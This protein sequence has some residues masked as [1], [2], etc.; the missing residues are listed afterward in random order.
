MNKPTVM[1]YAGPNGSG[2]ST[3]TAGYPIKG[4]YVNAD[5]IKQHRQCSDIEAAEEAEAIRESLLASS[6]D[7]TFET[8]L[9]TERNLLLLEKAKNSGYRIE[10][11]FVLTVDAELNIERVKTRVIQGGHDVP[12][13]KIRSRYIKS[14]QMLKRLAAISDSCIVIDNTYR[15]EII[16]KNDENG[17]I[18]LANDY[19]EISEIKELI[20]G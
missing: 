2:K 5:I 12:A 10:S 17:E 1:V 6:K 20:Q 4:I 15:P 11:I 7:F 3:I 16:Y 18:Y 14:L 19:W 8:V 13:D 9:S